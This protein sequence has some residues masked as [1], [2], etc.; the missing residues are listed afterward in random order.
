MPTDPR[1]LPSSPRPRVWQDTAAESL[2]G[3]AVSVI[4][5][6]GINP[7]VLATNQWLA[8]V[9]PGIDPVV[10]ML[11]LVI[12]LTTVLVLGGIRLKTEARRVTSQAVIFS[13]TETRATSSARAEA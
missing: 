4:A 6:T 3:G 7:L 1:P 5:L 9:A 12:A 13:R 8:T 2:L 11:L 10:T